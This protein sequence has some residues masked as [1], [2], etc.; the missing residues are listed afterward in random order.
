LEGYAGGAGVVRKLSNDFNP[1]FA[2]LLNEVIAPFVVIGWIG[3]R[4]D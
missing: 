3:V 4:F 1:V 2:V